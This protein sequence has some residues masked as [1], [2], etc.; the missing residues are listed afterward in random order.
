MKNKY[1]QQYEN[2]IVFMAQNK[3]ESGNYKIFDNDARV[4]TKR[5]FSELV[6][7]GKS[8]FESCLIIAN[9]EGETVVI[10]REFSRI[11]F[12]ALRAEN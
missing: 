10:T 2:Q 5:N 3:V 4:I 11:L 8:D 1:N 9:R 12:N 7:Q 6:E